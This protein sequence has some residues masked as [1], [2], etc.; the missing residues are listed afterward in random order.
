MWWLFKR[1]PVKRELWKKLRKAERKWRKYGRM[2]REAI[3]HKAMAR[4]EE[5]DRLST[6]WLGHYNSAVMRLY[7]K[8]YQ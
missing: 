1:D 3:K 7:P 5:Y 4:A 8:D 6:H 2:R